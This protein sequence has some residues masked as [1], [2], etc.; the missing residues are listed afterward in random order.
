[1]HTC[2]PLAMTARAVPPAAASRPASRNWCSPTNYR[3]SRWPSVEA[4][5]RQQRP[6]LS[7]RQRC[8]RQRRRRQRRRPPESTRTWRE[9]VKREGNGSDLDPQPTDSR[10]SD[11]GRGVNGRQRAAA[12]HWPAWLLIRGPNR[13]DSGLAR[14]KRAISRVGSFLPRFSPNLVVFRTKT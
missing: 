7:R 5:A 14:A 8:R 11:S 2:N 9:R 4:R 6:N 3:L 13:S 10:R 12:V 1:M